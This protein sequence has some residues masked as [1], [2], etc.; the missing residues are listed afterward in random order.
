MSSNVLLSKEIKSEKIVVVND[1]ERDNT[2]GFPVQYIFDVKNDDETVS[3]E[4]SRFVIQTPRMKCP[5]GISNDAM[6]TKEKDGSID[7]NK[8]KWNIQL[9]FAG[10][11]KSTKIQA[12]RD[13]IINRVDA[14]F[15]EIILK[16]ADKWI[17]LEDDEEEGPQFH[18]EKTVRKAYK[19]SLKKFKIKKDKPNDI[20][21]DNFKIT[22]PWDTDKNSEE[23]ENDLNFQGNPRKDVEFCDKNFNPISWKEVVKGSEVVAIFA[24][25][26]LFCTPGLGM[27][28]PS[29]KLLKLI[30][31]P[32]KRVSGFQFRIDND[33]E[34]EEEEE[35]VVEDEEEEDELISDPEVDEESQGSVV[36]N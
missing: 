8:L 10:E 12:F 17:P 3:Q 20:Y 35:I 23:D 5:F 6:F 13:A 27:M 18:T 9:S 28:G 30:V 34:V 2:K 25:N 33:E 21:P 4:S 15:K 32:P 36:E 16:N 11:D 14:K 29:C 24:I 31:Y 1:P 7:I 19:S 26:G 22:I